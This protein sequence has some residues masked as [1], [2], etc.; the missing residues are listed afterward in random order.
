VQPCFTNQSGLTGQ[1][2]KEQNLIIKD[3]WWKVFRNLTHMVPRYEYFIQVII[4]QIA[5][6]DIFVSG[7][8]AYVSLIMLMLIKIAGLPARCRRNTCSKLICY[9]LPQSL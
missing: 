2:T 6:H 5:Y 8:R 9:N 4:I 3:R 7:L 1:N